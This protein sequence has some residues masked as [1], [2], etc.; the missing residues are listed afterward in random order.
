MS[1][2]LR[3][4]VAKAVYEFN[5]Y[6]GI[7]SWQPSWDGEDRSRGTAEMDSRRAV[8][9][10]DAI[11]A[12]LA[13]ELVHVPPEGTEAVF[14]PPDVVDG[15][16]SA[17]YVDERLSDACLATQARRPKPEPKTERVLPIAVEPDEDDGGFVARSLGMPGTYGQGD[18]IVDA[19]ADLVAA[20]EAVLASEVLTEDPS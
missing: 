19:V 4:R 6:P 11:L 14:L 20:A 12:E 5:S 1:G 9:L 17:L 18:S 10:A 2:D 8:A 16:A 7:R 13:P 3:E 15:Y